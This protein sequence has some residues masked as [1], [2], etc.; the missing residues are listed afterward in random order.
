[1]R[2]A[3]E[4]ERITNRN[5]WNAAKTWLISEPTQSKGPRV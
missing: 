3:P 2:N 1:L 4:N 5:Q